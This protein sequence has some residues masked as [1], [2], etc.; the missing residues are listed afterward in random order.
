MKVRPAGKPD[1][2]LAVVKQAAGWFCGQSM[3][4]QQWHHGLSEAKFT[5][6]SIPVLSIFFLLFKLVDSA[7]SLYDAG[8]SPIFKQSALF[9]CVRLGIR[10]KFTLVESSEFRLDS[11]LFP[12][13]GFKES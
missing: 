13:F 7:N 4:G 1:G 8:S 2:R 12:A 5:E 9:Y 6:T 3:H 10:W 11:K